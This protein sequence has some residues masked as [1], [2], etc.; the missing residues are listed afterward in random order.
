MVSDLVV[1]GDC[2]FRLA[3]DPRLVLPMA[4][5]LGPDVNFHNSFARIKPPHTTAHL[6]WHQDFPH[7][8]HDRSELVKYALRRKLIRLV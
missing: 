2:W 6:D 8:R 4:D 7:D 3:T 5:L 1:A